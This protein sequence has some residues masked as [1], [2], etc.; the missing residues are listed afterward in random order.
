M[1]YMVRQKHNGLRSIAG[2]LVIIFALVS[3]LSSIQVGAQ[4][5][6]GMVAAA[7]PLAAEAGAEMLA[8]GGNAVDAAVAAAFAIG[9]VEPHASGLGG[10]GYMTIYLAET[11]EAIVID[12]QTEAPRAA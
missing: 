2:V 10:G 9:V 11:D 4:E 12:Y 3:A 5:S 8:K 6:E 7:H 1:L